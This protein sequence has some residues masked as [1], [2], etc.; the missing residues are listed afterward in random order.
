MKRVIK[1]S[2]IFEPRED[3]SEDT[4]KIK[5]CILRVCKRLQFFMQHFLQVQRIEE[6]LESVFHCIKAMLYWRFQYPGEL[7]SPLTNNIA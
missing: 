6:I 7:F 3:T 4:S 1:E 2:H 5:G